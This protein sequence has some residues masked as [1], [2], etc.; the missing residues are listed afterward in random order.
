[1]ENKRRWYDRARREMMAQRRT[2]REVGLGNA[3]PKRIRA[4][5]R[6]RNEVGL[7]NALPEQ[8]GSKV[9]SKR[10][11]VRKSTTQEVRTQRRTRKEVMVKHQSVNNESK[12][13]WSICMYIL[14]NIGP[15]FFMESS[16]SQKFESCKLQW[17]FRYCL[18]ELSCD[19]DLS[20]GL[21]IIILL[22]PL[23]FISRVAN[24]T[25]HFVFLKRDGI[26][27]IMYFWIATA[28]SCLLS[29]RFGFFFLD[30]VMWKKVWLFTR[31]YFLAKILEF[32]NYSKRRNHFDIGLKQTRYEEIQVI[33]I[34]RF[35]EVMKEFL[36]C[37][38]W[39]YIVM[40]YW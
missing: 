22:C 23:T 21:D 25:L 24:S 8:W 20:K 16:F 28:W 3:L 14:R 39:K 29:V 9:H 36:F 35:S 18:L 13:L 31:N 7:E 5:R 26:N 12:A 19:L 11:R 6:T 40:F 1:M 37:F 38:C 30:G 34:D 33:P 4:Q 27:P 15:S 32:Q 10:G 2:R 17:P